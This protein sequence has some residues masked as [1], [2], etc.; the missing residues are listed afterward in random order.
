MKAPDGLVKLDE[1][2][3][4][5]IYLTNTAKRR[6]HLRAGKV[7][8]D[9]RDP[10]TELTVRDKIDDEQRRFLKSRLPP[11]KVCVKHTKRLK[12]A[13]L[14]I[15]GAQKWCNPHLSLSTLLSTCAN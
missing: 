2:E 3:T 5:T 8:G 6:V 4:F 14:S 12:K 9:L 11:S 15:L 1:D 10:E 7:I 13:I